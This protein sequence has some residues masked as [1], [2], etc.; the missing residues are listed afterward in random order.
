MDYYVAQMLPMIMHLTQM[1]QLE[2]QESGGQETIKSKKYETLIV[3]LWELLPLFCKQNSANMY[4]CLA[5]LL[6]KLDELLNGDELGLRTT[7]L[8]TFSSLIT[9][10]KV[11]KVVDA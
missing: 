10:C 7:T 11:T 2:L 8:K 6:P 5:K 3:Q 4:G 1:R 9:H